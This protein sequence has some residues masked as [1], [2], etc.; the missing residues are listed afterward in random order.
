MLF[1]L[2]FVVCFWVGLGMIAWTIGAYLA[3]WRSP[4]RMGRKHPETID[5]HTGQQ[6]IWIDLTEGAQ[7]RRKAGSTERTAL[8]SQGHHRRHGINRARKWAFRAKR[9]I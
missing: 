2:F 3:F 1:I 8:Y 9:H 6:R 4:E 5:P 7:N